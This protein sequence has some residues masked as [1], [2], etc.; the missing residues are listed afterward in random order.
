MHCLLMSNFLFIMKPL[1]MA[2]TDRLNVAV[3]E[4]TDLTIHSAC[5]Q[6]NKFSPQYSGKLKLCKNKILY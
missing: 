4:T 2:P 6:K 1:L 5:M 3:A